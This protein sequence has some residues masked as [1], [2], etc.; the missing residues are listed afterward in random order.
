MSSEPTPVPRRIGACESHEAAEILPLVYAELRRLAASQ[1]GRLRPGQTLQPTALVHEAYL[2]LVGNRDPGWG[3]RGHFFGAAAQAMREIIV[4]H[5]RRKFAQK[6][7]GG[8][9]AEELDTAIAVAAGDLRIDDALAVDAAL[10]KLEAEHPRQARVVVMR[11][12]GGL[13]EDEIAR[14]LDV[15]SRTVERDWRFAS[16]YLHAALTAEPGPAR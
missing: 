3:G 12:F 8:R 4:D 5:L 1:L 6:R 7:G 14:A 15:T 16:A 11:Y 10:K 2:K 9:P 13:S